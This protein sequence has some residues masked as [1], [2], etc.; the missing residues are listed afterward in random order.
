MT[1]RKRGAGSGKNRRVISN[2]C[3][4]SKENH[5]V[6]LEMRCNRKDL[7]VDIHHENQ[8][9]DASPRNMTRSSKETVT[10][11]SCP[12]TPPSKGRRRSAYYCFKLQLLE[13]EQSAGQENA[14]PCR[15]FFPSSIAQQGTL[16][17][18]TQIHLY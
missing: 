16:K 13:T 12:I 18:D 5:K 1:T 15:T 8:V 6:L 4:C 14:A 7:F 11:T 3:E 10:L 2:G 9:L 17:L